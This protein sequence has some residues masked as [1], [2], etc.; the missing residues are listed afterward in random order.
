MRQVG[1]EVQENCTSSPLDVQ[2]VLVWSLSGDHCSKPRLQRGPLSGCASLLSAATN[3]PSNNKVAW[4]ICFLRLSTNCTCPCWMS[5]RLSN[6]F[7]MS[8]WRFAPVVE[9]HRRRRSRRRR[10]RRRSRRRS[11]RRRRRR[12]RRSSRNKK[13]ARSQLNKEPLEF[14]GWESIVLKDITGAACIQQG[15]RAPLSCMSMRLGEHVRTEH[16]TSDWRKHSNREREWEK[17]KLEILSWANKKVTLMSKF[18]KKHYK[19]GIS[20]GPNKVQFLLQVSKIGRFFYFK[21]IKKGDCLQNFFCHPI[22]K[23]EIV[24]ISGLK[25]GNTKTA[26]NTIE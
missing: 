20:E 14:S 13:Q 3:H 17:K 21:K 11:R 5:L 8:C 16:L 4:L 22:L 2:L 15:G 12:R 7:S 6:E 26:I 23:P 19:I 25:K 9:G 10:R 1:W 24:T 18:S